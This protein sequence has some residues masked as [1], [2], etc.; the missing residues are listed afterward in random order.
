MTT[1][2]VESVRDEATGLFSLSIHLPAEAPE[3][4]VTTAPR[5]ATAEAGANDVVAA[6]AAFANRPRA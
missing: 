5:Y 6:I 1:I 2:R 4:F 3:P